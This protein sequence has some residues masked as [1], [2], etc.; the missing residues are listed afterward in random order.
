MKFELGEND[1]FKGYEVKDGKRY[2][3]VLVKH[4]ITKSLTS[5]EVAEINEAFSLFDKDQSGNIDVLELKDAMKALGIYMSKEQLKETMDK[6]DKDG[7]GTIEIGEF[8]ALMA[9]KINQRNPKEEVYKAFRMYDDDDGGT[10]DFVNLRKVATELAYENI[11]D[12]DCIKM[13]KIADTKGRGEVDIEDFMSV[14]R[15]G[16]LF[17]SVNEDPKSSADNTPRKNE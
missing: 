1:E 14:M 5:E 11:T 3:K 10:I 4:S 17:E 12:E 9:E 7:S 6:A 13:I 16:G 8:L 2:K 15:Q